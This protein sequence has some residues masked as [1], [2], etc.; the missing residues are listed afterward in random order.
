[1]S[2]LLR[3]AGP[4]GLSPPGWGLPPGKPQPAGSL[5]ALPLSVYFIPGC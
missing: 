5:G 3:R 4:L 1:M 2:I